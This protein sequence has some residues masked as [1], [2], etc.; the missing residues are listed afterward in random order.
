[1]KRYLVVACLIFGFG[2]GLHAQVVD[3]T[4]CDIV[5]NPKSFDGKIVRI[6]GTVSWIRSVR[7]YPIPIAD[8]GEWN[9]AFL[10]LGSKGKAGPVV[11]VEVQPAHNYA[12]PAKPVTRT[13]VTLEK[14]KDFK[15]FDSLLSQTRYKN[16]VCFACFKNKVNATVVGRLDGVSEAYLHHDPSGKV[17]Q[18][19]EKD[20]GDSR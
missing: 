19:K 13:P 7:D 9:L 12:G 16:G 6:K 4:V 10:S 2:L 14:N 20:G 15:Q 8:S 1:M 17:I 3:A 5:K 11:V 18:D